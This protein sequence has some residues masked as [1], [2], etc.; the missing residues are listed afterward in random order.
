MYSPMFF[1]FPP[2][3]FPLDW[4]AFMCETVLEEGPVTGEPMV[5]P[6]ASSTP[7]HPPPIPTVR[8]VT[9]RILDNH[10]TPV[11]RRMLTPTSSLRR[12]PLRPTDSLLAENTWNKV[13]DQQPTYLLKHYRVP[14]TVEF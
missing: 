2:S 10:A 8:A 5:R 1:L 13:K 9:R 4:A 12:R 11:L 14:S 3:L 6:V 7:I